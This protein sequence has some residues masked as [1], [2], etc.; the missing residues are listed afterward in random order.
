MMIYIAISLLAVVALCELYRT[1]LGT[2]PLTKK[3]HFKRKLEGARTMV[4]DLQFKVFKTREI[5]EDVRQEYD[6]VKSR[7]QSIEKQIQEWPSEGDPEELARVKDSKE[8]A[9][10]DLARFQQ[11]MLQLDL[12]VEG[13]KPSVDLPNGYEGI[14]MQIDSLRELEGMLK[15]WI[16]EL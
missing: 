14:T 10:R 13:A 6:F 8:L 2:L 5:R 7:L 15:D 11:Q 16:R 1:F 4:W 9:E 3:A 12:E